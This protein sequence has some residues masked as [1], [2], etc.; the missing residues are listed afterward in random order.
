MIDGEEVPLREGDLF[1]FDPEIE[2]G[3]K[4]GPDGLV[5]VAV[6]VGPGAGK[7]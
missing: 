2:R 4:A 1:C 3:P 7:T 5:M 6:G